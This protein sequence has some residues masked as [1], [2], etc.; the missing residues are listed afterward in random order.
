[1]N[2]L[3]EYMTAAEITPIELSKTTGIAA[4]V[5]R[6]LMTDELITTA[7]K[8]TQKKV[9]DAL[10][11]TVAELTTGGN[12]MKDKLLYTEVKHAVEVL[13]RYARRYS[14]NQHY[15]SITILTR[16]DSAVADDYPN[17]IPDSYSFI[18]SMA[19]KDETNSDL[20]F[21]PIVN[22][23]GRIFYWE[24]DTEGI[25]KVVPNERE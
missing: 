1:M 9:A 22:E 23:S 19:D 17:E 6:R 14:D 21:I 11:V 18:V 16:D 25:R 10:G 20:P 5:I 24:D 12:S 8:K 7:H 2:Y 4:S 13:A 15:V 3:T